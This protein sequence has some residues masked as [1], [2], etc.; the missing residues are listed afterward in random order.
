MI[1]MGMEMILAIIKE[2]MFHFHKE[3]GIAQLWY[4][5]YITSLRCIA[6]WSQWYFI[7]KILQFLSIIHKKGYVK[8]RAAYM[9]Q[10]IQFF[11]IR[12]Q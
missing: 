1:V 7:F 5:G 2:V 8:G 12:Y 4:K 3:N 11:L 6:F 10:N 9:Y